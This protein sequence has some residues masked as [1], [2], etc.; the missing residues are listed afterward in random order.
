MRF[1]LKLLKLTV[2]QGKIHIHKVL[3]KTD[4]IT[5]SLIIYFLNNYVK[6]SNQYK[7]MIHVLL[8]S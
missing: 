7:N 2:Q 8:R 6:K 4:K 3:I 1:H 5:E